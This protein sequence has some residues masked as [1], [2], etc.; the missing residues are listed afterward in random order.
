MRATI[1]GRHLNRAVWPVVV[2]IGWF[3]SAA[4]GGA[5][6]KITAPQRLLTGQLFEL[7]TTGT[8]KRKEL[9]GT[10]FFIA[11]IQPNW[12]ACQ[13][14]AQLEKSFPSS[15]MYYHGS[16]KHSPFT[17]VKTFTAGG[18]GDRRV[19]AYL[20]SRYILPRDTTKPIATATAR[21]QTAAP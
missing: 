8:F 4:A 3:G 9:T 10:A 19:C 16:E 18:T 7:R 5:T 20:Y 11:F 15:V 13:R 1:G 2:A 14:T 6:L 17:E 21:Y 12:N